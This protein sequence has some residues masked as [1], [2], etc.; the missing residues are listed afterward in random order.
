VSTSTQEAVRRAF[1]RAV[2]AR[3]VDGE[4]CT[5]GA[6]ALSKATGIPGRTVGETLVILRDEGA[7]PEAPPSSTRIQDMDDPELE[8]R[9]RQDA[10]RC[11]IAISEHLRAQGITGNLETEVGRVD[12]G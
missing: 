12:H 7:I 11:L 6:G 1:W 2:S 9:N 5:A 10:A 4:R 8:E 3:L